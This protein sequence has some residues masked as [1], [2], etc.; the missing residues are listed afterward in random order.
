[1]VS[2]FMTT[3]PPRL[4][5]HS[6]A[7]YSYTFTPTGEDGSIL[8]ASLSPGNSSQA[9]QLMDVRHFAEANALWIYCWGI[10]DTLTHAILIDRNTI[11]A[12]IESLRYITPIVFYGSPLQFVLTNLMPYEIQWSCLVSYALLDV[13][14]AKALVERRYMR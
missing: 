8:I 5:R 9:I 3:A 6:E 1:M 4:G 2:Q 7:V 10:A 14:A 11:D 13:E 12:G